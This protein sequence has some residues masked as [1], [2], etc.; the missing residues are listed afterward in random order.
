MTAPANALEKTFSDSSANAS[1]SANGVNASDIGLLALRVGFGGLLAA[2]GAQKLFG[3][4]G[5]YGLEA[6]QGAFEQMGYNPGKLFGTLA[7]LS[8]LTGGLLLLL[9]LL[10]PLAAAIALGTM[11]N[12][13]NATWSNGLFGGAQPGY[14]MALLFAI[15]AFTLAFTGPGRFSLDAGRPWQRQ[16]LVWGG[17]AVAVAL[18]AGV[19]TLIL[20]WAL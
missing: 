11:V 14:E 9:G 3:W 8:E 10:T 4:F 16:G 6:T 15:A 19:V 18:G 17:L 13:V 5:G 2:H 12:A 7:G 1:T 20:K